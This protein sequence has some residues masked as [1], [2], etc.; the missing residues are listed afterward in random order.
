MLRLPPITR[1]LTGAALMIAL[2]G[3]ATAVSHGQTISIAALVNDEPISAFD[4]QQ[5]TRF[6]ALTT[7]SKPSEALRKK[8]LEALIDERLQLQEAK[9]Q[10]VP[11]P[12]E[13]VQEALKSIAQKNKMDLNSFKKALAGSG[14]SI[15]TFADTLRAKMAW[16]DVMQTKYARW[17][18]V[19]QQQVDKMVGGAS[20]RAAE[21]TQFELQKV[22][23]PISGSRDDRALMARMDDA[24]KLRR[25]FSGCKTLK[26][27]LKDVDGAKV[28]NL[29][30]RMPEK[31]GEPI[32]SVLLATKVGQM[33]PPTVAG[34][35][36][37][38]FAVCG[39]RTIRADSEQR[40]QAMN[41]LF[42]QE[43]GIVSRRKLRD[44]RDNAVIVYR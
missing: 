23:L 2:M 43:L 44:L 7:R 18:S 19:N 5:R 4:V 12:E 3:V 41:K 13:K 14:V 22:L 10:S 15:E 6:L 34:G 29:G 20:E 31:F 28:Q 1:R 26:L 24:E 37:E 8:A 40:Q 27:L 38:M 9:R 30:R 35:A 33:T 17:V 16:R 36:V 11:V 42:S 25:K 32:Q 21:T 39:R